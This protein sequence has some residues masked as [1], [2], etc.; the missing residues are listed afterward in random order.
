MATETRRA[1]VRVIKREQRE[2]ET[3]SPPDSTPAAS[4]RCTNRAMAAAVGSWIEE[5]RQHRESETA[6]LFARLFAGANI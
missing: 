2:L 3:Q 4:E 6:N 5:F 1:A